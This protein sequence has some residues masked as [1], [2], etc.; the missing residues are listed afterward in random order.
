MQRPETDY[1]QLETNWKAP[2]DDVD[3]EK[4]LEK[5]HVDYK[6]DTITQEAHELTLTKQRKLPSPE[7]GKGSTKSK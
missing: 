1:A 6:D 5:Q 2:N 4:V 3:L 7:K